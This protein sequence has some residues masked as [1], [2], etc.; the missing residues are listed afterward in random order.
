MSIEFE[1]HRILSKIEGTYGVD[2]GPDGSNRIRTTGVDI[3]PYA[4]QR[5]SPEYDGDGGRF[6]PSINT[7]PHVGFKFGID[8]AGS[9]VLATAPNFGEI[10]RACGLDETVNV[11]VDVQ[12]AI[13]V[14][15]T[16]SVTIWGVRKEGTGLQLAKSA[17]VRGKVGI[18]IGAGQLPLFNFDNML[19]SYL[20]PEYSGTALTEVISNQQKAVPMT[21]ANTTVFTLDGQAVCPE[22]FTLD[23]FGWD[24]VRLPYCEETILKP[25]PITGS[26]KI[27]DVGIQTKNWIQFAESHATVQELPIVITHGIVAGSILSLGSSKLQITDITEDQIE[28][29][30]AYN[31]TFILLENPVLTMT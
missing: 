7:N 18:S 8:Y 27:K 17:G 15:P 4:G 2:S 10:L 30:K 14:D 6:R 11:G 28:G 25:I 16:D 26:L 19:G 20:R 31:L 21:K 29:A 23:N 24:S 12:Y 9:G 3:T 1:S 13:A 22:S 5:Q